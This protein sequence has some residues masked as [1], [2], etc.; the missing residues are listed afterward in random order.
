MKYLLQGLILMSLAG[1]RP[2]NWEFH[3]EIKLSNIAP[4]GIVATGQGLWVSDVEGNRVILVGLDGEIQKTFNGFKRPM[5]IARH[6]DIVYVPE[7]ISDTLKIIEGGAVVFM[8]WMEKLDGPAAIAVAD[9]G[10]AVADFY[11]NRVLFKK[12]ELLTIIGKEGHQAGE[13]YYPTDVEFYDHRIYVADAYNNR[14]QVFDEGGKG[15]Q[16]IGE[17]DGIHVA[18]GIALSGNSIFVTDFEGNRILIYDL[19]GTL[20]QIL[21][22]NL[23]NPTDIAV[24][25]NR[26]YIANYGGNSILEFVRE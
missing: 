8:P 5:H 4:L 19:E 23:K 3:R 12:G 17:A 10:M 24:Y 9:E 14:V 20:L 13:L 11:N 15:I 21:S 7:Y 26:L 1:C 6:Q 18:T 16:V 22:E 25:Q 2:S